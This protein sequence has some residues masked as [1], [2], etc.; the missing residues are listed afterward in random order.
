[1][2]VNQKEVTSHLTQQHVARECLPL[3]PHGSKLLRGRG[4]HYTSHTHYT[5]LHGDHRKK[6]L[7]DVVMPM[8]KDDVDT[9]VGFQ[10]MKS[11]GLQDKVC[12][13]QVDP[14]ICYKSMGC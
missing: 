4:R 7:M 12:E 8:E 6:D 1:M 10:L 13:I 11:N 3:A 9:R 2:W 5:S 14:T